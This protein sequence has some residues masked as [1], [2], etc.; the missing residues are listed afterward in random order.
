MLELSMAGT[1][2]GKIPAIGLDPLDDLTNRH[3]HVLRLIMPES[4]RLGKNRRPL[5]NTA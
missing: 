2:A 4:T 1:L 5:P 3:V